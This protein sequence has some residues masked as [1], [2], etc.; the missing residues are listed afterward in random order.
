[1]KR[2]ILAQ[3][4]CFSDEGNEVSFRLDMVHSDRG[5][6]LRQPL[7]ILVSAPHLRY[8]LLAYLFNFN[9]MPRAIAQ[10]R[11]LCLPWTAHLSI[12]SCPLAPP[13]IPPV[14]PKAAPT[15]SQP[16]SSQPSSYRCSLHHPPLPMTLLSSISSIFTQRFSGRG[17]CSTVYTSIHFLATVPPQSMM[18]CPRK[19]RLGHALK[20]LRPSSSGSTLRV[21]S[22]STSSEEAL[23][24]GT[25]HV[26]CNLLT[27][28][29]T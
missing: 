5:V 2:A 29:F 27:C 8:R 15:T 13:S 22:L 24:R 7:L 3:Y 16:S 6:T 23:V 14:L 9:V 12:Y 18:R 25:S 19:Y 20:V 28:P 17:G 11:G 1:M 10:M 21:K 26:Q 4:F